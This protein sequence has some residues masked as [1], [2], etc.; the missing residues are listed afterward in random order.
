[1]NFTVLDYTEKNPLE[2]VKTSIVYG[3]SAGQYGPIRAI[4]VSELNVNIK[5]PVEL[6]VII[7]YSYNVST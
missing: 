3:N 7:H 1:M 6:I 2:P 4:N 5:K